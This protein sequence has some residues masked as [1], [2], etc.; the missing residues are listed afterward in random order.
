MLDRTFLVE[1]VRTSLY[2]GKLR[3]GVQPGLNAIIDAW[4]RLAPAAD[5]RW[6]AYSL[7]TAYHETAATFE[8]LREWGR[9]K[10]RKYGK[11][12]PVNGHVYYGRGYVQLTWRDNYL[13]MGKKLGF[14]F[15]SNPDKVMDPKI[16][17]EILVRGMIDGDFTTRGLGRY[18]LGKKCDYIGARYII[19]GKDKAELIAGYAVKFEK[20][21]RHL[22]AEQPVMVEAPKV[23]AIAEAPAAVSTTEA[24]YP[25]A[26]APAVVEAP[27]RPTLWNRIKSWFA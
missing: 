4:E 13:K 23:E 14:D 9:G 2:K 22:T 6:I 1:G 25:Q 24:T 16:A 26:Q 7:A 3:P 18:I 21:L 15:V 10:G 8:P 5:L 27:E 19:N 12:D 17:A 11:P 20:C